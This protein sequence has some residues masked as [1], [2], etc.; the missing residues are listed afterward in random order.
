MTV[1]FRMRRLPSILLSCAVA[2]GLATA[3]LVAG[4]CNDDDGGDELSL[5]LFGDA[6]ELKAYRTLTAAYEEETGTRVRLIPIPDRD[7]HHQKLTTA[8]G[9]GRPPDVFLVN[10]RN[11]GGFAAKG[12][13]DPAGPRL[14][15]STTLQRDSFY[16]E[17][18]EAFEYRGELQ[19]MP[20]NVSSLVVYYNRELFRDAGVPEPGGDWTLDDLRETAAR[21]KEALG[22]GADALGV[23]PVMV[24]AAPFVWSA[25]GEL[26]DDYDEPTRFTLDTPAA[27]AGLEDL[28]G[29]VD[30]GPL[31]LE[32]RAKPMDE[33]FLSGELA[34]V[35][36]SRA[37]VPTFRTAEFDWDV[38]P[39]PRGRQR[40]GILHSDAYCIA[41]DGNADDAWRFVEFA[42]GR[43]GAEITANA[44]RTVPSL[45]KVSTS[46]AFLDPT[47]RPRNSQ[48]FLDAVP[49]IRRLPTSPD[50][51]RL[52]EGADI[53]IEEAFYK[54]LGADGVIRRLHKETD[55]VFR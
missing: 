18:L 27:R 17:A 7:S 30:Y 47:Q 24:R 8:F 35:M 40:A 42:V 44:G 31:E 12:V 22:E 15:S 53:A 52:E 29:L 54:R 5:Q 3:A 11:F 50:W 23:D 46:R 21:L 2:T 39:F 34:M 45:R 37:E 38:A 25:G 32:A 51:P 28:L 43:Q 1:S 48:V 49:T 9:A 14:D 10:Y 20:Q 19:C 16:E 6:E 36:G 4:G 55:D 13:L 26:V 41:K 33:R